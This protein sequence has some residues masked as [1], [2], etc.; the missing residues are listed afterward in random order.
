M[1]PASCTA[2]K[3]FP[4]HGRVSV[5]SHEALPILDVDAATWWEEDALPFRAAVEAGVPIVMLGHLAV[6]SLGRVAGVAVARGCPRA[7]AGSGVHRGHRQ[8]RSRHGRPGAWNPFEIVD[9]AVAAGVD[10]LLFVITDAE[11]AALVDH[12]AARIEGGDV[13]PERVTG[14]VSRVLRMQLGMP[15]NC[16][17]FLLSRGQAYHSRRGGP[18]PRA[19]R[20]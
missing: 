3:H 8:R 5:D 4:G 16:E 15:V 18:T 1:A 2:S 20:R 19:A 10:L 14:S 12:L 6:P 17:S 7:A 9:L 11:L 13:P